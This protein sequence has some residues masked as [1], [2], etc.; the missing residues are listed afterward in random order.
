MHVFNQYYGKCSAASRHVPAVIAEYPAAED[1]VLTGQLVE[2]L[3]LAV[4]VQV[5]NSLTVR[6]GQ[7]I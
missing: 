6:T 7:E 4:P 1:G 3:A 5:T 2:S